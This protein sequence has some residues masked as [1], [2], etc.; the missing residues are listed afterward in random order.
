[1]V[2]L[3]F[4]SSH[5]LD[6]TQC[7]VET[8]GEMMPNNLAQAL[9]E[10]LRQLSRNGRKEQYEQLDLDEL[11]QMSKEMLEELGV[12]EIVVATQ[13]SLKCRAVVELIQ[14][15]G[16]VVAEQDMPVMS[17]STGK[18]EPDWKDALAVAYDKVQA[19]VERLKKNRKEKRKGKKE[20]KPNRLVL[21]GD[22]VV[23][24]LDNQG[25]VQYLGNL[26]RLK[27]AEG[28]R[29]KRLADRISELVEIYKQDAK[30]VYQ[31][32][33]VG[34]LKSNK[35]VYEGAT[36]VNI[37]VELNPIPEKVVRSFFTPDKVGRIMN[38]AAGIPIVALKGEESI[39]KYIKSVKIM[40]LG[41]FY[42]MK[43]PF[44]RFDNGQPPLERKQIP[45]IELDPKNSQTQ[46][47]LRLAV[48]GNIPPT[49]L[50]L[51]MG[52]RNQVNQAS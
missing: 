32:A 31:V 34:S 14:F 49:F 42:S 20:S 15:L 21:G 23:G 3:L 1:M 13:N 5:E 41:N 43:P 8:V 17:G 33:L 44:G 50:D 52:L 30:I 9:I 6:L 35:Q 37:V 26:S 27:E 47:L 51:F 36:G 25:G 18:E 45:V 7:T 16:V 19:L 24:W 48:I 28:L 22:I 4:M 29:G 11:R 38:I 2:F 12:G 10:I 39:Y 40:S 46:E